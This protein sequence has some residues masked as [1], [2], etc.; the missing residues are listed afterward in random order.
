[1]LQPILLALLLPLSLLT[2][3][4][5][6]MVFTRRSQA[7]SV[8]LREVP[9]QSAAPAPPRPWVEEAEVQRNKIIIE[10]MLQGLSGR[11]DNYAR[12]AR[13]YGE[14]LTQHKEALQQAGNLRSMRDIE[15][16][17]VDEVEA[18][19]RSNEAYRQQLDVA[20]KTILEQ[21]DQLDALS[22]EATFDFLTQ[23]PNRRSFDRRLHDEIERYRRGGPPFSLV[24]LDIDH[25]KQVNDKHGHQ[26]GD[27]VL[28]GVAHLLE[29]HRRATDFV[30]RFG[31]EEFALLFPCTGEHAA[32]QAIDKIREEL[33][34]SP[35]AAGR[36]VLNITFSGGVA[37]MLPADKG[38][39][40]LIQRAD[41]R[42]Y[43]AKNNGRNLVVSR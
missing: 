18:M 26:A 11:V 1:M 33:A 29:A 6:Y 31:G 35:L 34:A 5:G 37:E 8:T 15:Q 9:T 40:T 10:D 20:N 19:R 16:L 23:I 12:D 39:A 27:E 4:L 36:V 22:F 30:A 17:L 2:L 24:L 32:A 13:Q 21:R 28:R 25:F 43:R 3:L 38:T 41:E 14:S 42:L 7:N